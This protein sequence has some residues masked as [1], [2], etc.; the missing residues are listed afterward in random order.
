[1]TTPLTDQDHI[2]VLTDREIESYFCNS[3]AME[4]AIEACQSD[5]ARL[6][7]LH[8]DNRVKCICLIQQQLMQWIESEARKDAQEA[9]YD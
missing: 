8:W 9:Y 3:S 2:D 1:M 5:I 7:V 6:V 4:K